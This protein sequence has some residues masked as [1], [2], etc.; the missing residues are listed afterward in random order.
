MKIFVIILLIAVGIFLFR[1][2]QRLAR[3]EQKA[4]IPKSA[5]EK[6]TIVVENTPPSVPDTVPAKPKEQTPLVVAIAVVPEVTVA[7]VPEVTAPS[8]SKVKSVAKPEVK[9]NATTLGAWANAALARAFAEYQQTTTVT[10]RY[11]ALQHM[12]GECY[13]QRKLTQYRDYG[14]QLADEYLVLFDNALMENDE[15]SELKSSGFLQLATLLTDARAFDAAIAL[16]R[17][18]LDLGLSDGTVTGF[19]GR[20]LRIEKAQ[21]K[22]TTV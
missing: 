19:E 14:A 7:M 16:C 17:K 15:N 22:A 10:E 3:E 21:H 18:A 5:M 9:S 8:P 11:T 4:I 6:S 1:R 13:K 20:I 12:I 2:A